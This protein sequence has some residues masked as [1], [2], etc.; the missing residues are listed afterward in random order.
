MKLCR[1]PPLECHVL[2]EWTL[3]L[4]ATAFDLRHSLWIPFEN[5]LGGILA[6]VVVPHKGPIITVAPKPKL[7]ER[8]VRA[9]NN[10]LKDFKYLVQVKGVIH[11]FTT[12]ESFQLINHW[13][14]KK[15][16]VK[17]QELSVPTW[18][19]MFWFLGQPMVQSELKNS[20]NLEM[21]NVS[22]SRVMPPSS[23]RIWSLFTSLE[24]C[25]C[26]KKKTL[27][28]IFKYL[29]TP[30]TCITTVVSRIWTSLT[31]LWGFGLA[32]EIFFYCHRC[33]KKWCLHN[34]WSN[35]TQK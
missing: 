17:I 31:W 33:L 24:C 2:F 14:P 9:S 4:C 35:V 13:V 3:M 28:K 18:F 10:Y 23:S 15:V 20:S 29:Q 11:H 1:P 27:L 19:P 16:R 6:G 25:V 5:V 32:Q 21:T 8:S 26:K 34:K 30:H 12:N 22:E 7:N